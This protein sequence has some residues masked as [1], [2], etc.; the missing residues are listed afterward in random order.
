MGAKFEPRDLYVFPTTYVYAQ[1]WENF[2]KLTNNGLSV[3]EAYRY[4]YRITLKK[5]KDERKGSFCR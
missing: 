3:K 1:N 2:S 4:H 5:E